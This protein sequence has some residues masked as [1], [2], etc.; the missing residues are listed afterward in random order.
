MVFL[1]LFDQAIQSSSP[2]FVL[3]IGEV[4]FAPKVNHSSEKTEDEGYLVTFIYVAE[5]GLSEFWVYDAQA[6]EKG[7]LAKVL[8]PARIPVCFLLFIYLLTCSQYG[9][10]GKFLTDH[11]IEHQMI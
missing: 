6:P 11:Q 3:K 5:T 2:L 8:I 9:F 7:P 10:H 1:I 4:A